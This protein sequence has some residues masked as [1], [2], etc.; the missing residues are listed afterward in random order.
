[1]MCHAIGDARRGVAVDLCDVIPDDMH[2][3]WALPFAR[4]GICASFAAVEMPR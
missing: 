3:G 1:M 4:S 2:G